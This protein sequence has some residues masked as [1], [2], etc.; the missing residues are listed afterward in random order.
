MRAQVKGKLDQLEILMITSNRPAS[1]ACAA[2]RRPPPAARRPPPASPAMRPA[3]L[4]CSLARRI[5][6]PAHSTLIAGCTCDVG[7][8]PELRAD[9]HVAAPLI[10]R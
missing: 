6:V 9:G 2:S 4:P 1:S 8:E 10:Q 5:S 7:S 3:C